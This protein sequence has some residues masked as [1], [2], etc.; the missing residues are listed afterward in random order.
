MTD[1]VIRLFKLS[2]KGDSLRVGGEREGSTV[3]QLKYTVKGRDIP[4]IPNSSWKGVFKRISEGIAKAK[5]IGTASS[6][7]NDDHPKEKRNNEEANKRVQ[8]ILEHANV[9]SEMNKGNKIKG[10]Q[11]KGIDI[12]DEVWTIVRSNVS[13]DYVTW[14][15]LEE[16]TAKTVYYYMCPVD[17]L[18]GSKLFASSISFSDSLVEG[19]TSFQPHV[20]LD[21]TFGAQKEK[22]LF[23]EEV[24]EPSNITLRVVLR[25]EGDVQLWRYTLRYVEKMGIAVG[26][27]KSR[28]LGHLTLDVEESKVGEVDGVNVKWDGLKGFLRGK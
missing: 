25:P 28:G 1:K 2:F 3:Y 26:G 16:I 6:H 7:N 17:R 22:R 10:T 24:V 5:G 12:D 20:V 23:E 8:S 21:R 19:N 15:D 4:V 18:Y 27:S 9:K 14:E 13:A 11:L